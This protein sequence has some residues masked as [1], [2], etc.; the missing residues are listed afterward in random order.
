MAARSFGQLGPARREPAKR[1]KTVL[2]PLET[3]IY[4][5]AVCACLVRLG[6]A[7]RMRHKVEEGG[8]GPL[9]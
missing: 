9:A 1:T 4:C 2:Q 6:G 5:P 3:E 8:T 7:L